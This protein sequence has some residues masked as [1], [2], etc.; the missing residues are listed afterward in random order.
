MPPN[1]TFESDIPGVL[2]TVIRPENFSTE[3]FII[4]LRPET[5]RP[6]TVT[7]PF[8]R[9]PKDSVLILTDRMTCRSGIE[10][11]GS[12]TV[13]L[14]F[15]VREG[16]FADC[17]LGLDRILLQKCTINREIFYPASSPDPAGSYRHIIKDGQLTL[18]TRIS[19]GSLDPGVFDEE[20]LQITGEHPAAM[21]DQFD[22]QL[23]LGITGVSVYQSPKGIITQPEIEIMQIK[24]FENDLLPIGCIP[25]S[26][27]ID[28][29]EESVPDDK[30]TIICDDVLEERIDRAYSARFTPPV[31][32]LTLADSARLKE[33][34][35]GI[36]EESSDDDT[37]V[38]G[39]LE[40]P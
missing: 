18:Y 15:A 26:S 21:A 30:A 8:Y 13:R 5:K 3:K 32:P 33:S 20:G 1:F 9:A 38:N 37:A 12:G 7:Y 31:V 39:L 35:P 16:P 6:G 29:D 40:D 22:A 27:G 11:I 25:F 17:V 2:Y 24:L 4:G 34:L 14:T 10:I 19:A 23:I 28:A 36:Q